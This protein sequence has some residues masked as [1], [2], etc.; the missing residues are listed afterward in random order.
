MRHLKLSMLAAA[1]GLASHWLLLAAFGPAEWPFG[2]V[3]TL[4][5]AYGTAVA[6]IC[7]PLL[8]RRALAD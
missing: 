4:K 2:T 3:L 1:A 8:L 6:A 5:I 7:A